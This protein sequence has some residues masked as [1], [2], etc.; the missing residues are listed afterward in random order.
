VRGG[1][2][3]EGIVREMF[4]FRRRRGVRTVNVGIDRETL[5]AGFDWILRFG[6]GRNRREGGRWVGG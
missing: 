6:F 4:A 3:L 1:K 5:G 2:V